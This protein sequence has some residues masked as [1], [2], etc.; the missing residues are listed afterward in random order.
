MLCPGSVRHRG[1]DGV[2]M[3]FFQMVSLHYVLWENQEYKI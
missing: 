3:E 1:A 2:L